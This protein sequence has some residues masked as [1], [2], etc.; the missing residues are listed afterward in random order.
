MEFGPYVYNE[1]DE[2]SNVTYNQ[3]VNPA[4]GKN[5]SAVYAQ[6]SQYS[7]FKDDG[8]GNIDEDMYLLNQA[9]LGVWHRVNNAPKW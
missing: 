4:T 5:E 1:F 7:E 3:A 8:D 9:T 2:Y 6:Y